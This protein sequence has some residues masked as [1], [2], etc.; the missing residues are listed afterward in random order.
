MIFDDNMSNFKIYINIKIMIHLIL[1]YILGFWGFTVLALFVIN[2][3]VNPYF[4]F[5]YLLT[6]HKGYHFAEI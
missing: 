4:I 5:Y 1:I 6:Q 3:V 2:K